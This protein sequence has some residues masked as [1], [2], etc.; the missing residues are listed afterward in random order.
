[1]TVLCRF[2]D[3]KIY[4]NSKWAIKALIIESYKTNNGNL[5]E[6]LIIVAVAIIH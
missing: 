6:R 2:S 4:A 3:D 1:M 5:I